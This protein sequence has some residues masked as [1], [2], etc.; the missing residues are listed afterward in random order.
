MDVFLWLCFCGVNR[1]PARVIESIS[2]DLHQKDSDYRMARAIHAKL[3]VLTVDG[4]TVL[5][6]R[7]QQ[8]AMENIGQG[9]NQDFLWGYFQVLWQ[10]I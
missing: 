3:G 5:G 4:V 10:N 2:G 1:T 8:S 6:G 9:R 7:H